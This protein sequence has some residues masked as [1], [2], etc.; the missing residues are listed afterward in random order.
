TNGTR[1]KNKQPMKNAYARLE[2]PF[3]A[4]SSMQ[5]MNGQRSFPRSL[6]NFWAVRS[7]DDRTHQRETDFA[8]RGINQVQLRR[9][10]MRDL[11]RIRAST[12]LARLAACFKAVRVS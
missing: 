3:R 2:S 9:R 11:H 12:S 6:P 7:I 5:V 4:W 8:V 10:V 1:P